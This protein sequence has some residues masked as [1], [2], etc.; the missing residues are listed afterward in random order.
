[1]KCGKGSAFLVLVVTANLSFG[2]LQQEDTVNSHSVVQLVC[3]DIV[4]NVRTTSLRTLL[5]TDP[6]LQPEADIAIQEIQQ[7][8]GDSL[9]QDWAVITLDGRF[10]GASPRLKWHAPKISELTAFV[11]RDSEVLVMRHANDPEWHSAVNV[12]RL[13]DDEIVGAIQLATQRAQNNY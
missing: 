11:E 12:I 4:D 8:H 13:L 2:S 10:E 5:S 9:V 1:M 7:G 6:K 3:R